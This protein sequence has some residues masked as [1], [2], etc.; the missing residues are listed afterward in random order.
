M[1]CKS[2][3]CHNDAMVARYEYDSFGNCT[4]YDG[5]GTERNDGDFIGNIN[6][7][8]WKSFYYDAE[9]GLYYAN[10]SYYDP[11]TCLYLNALSMDETVNGAYLTRCLDRYGLM[12]DN[13]LNFT[14]KIYSIGDTLNPIN[15]VSAKMLRAL[16][17]LPQWLAVS[18]SALSNTL[19]FS[20]YART[21]LYM[22]R[23]PEIIQLMKFDGVTLLPGKYT[24]FI[25]GAAYGFVA[26]DTVF[27]IY[28]NIQNNKPTGYVIG[29]AVYTAATG[30]GIVWASGKI[31]TVIGT[32]IG[33]P[34]GA[35]AGG[36]I[37]LGAGVLLSWLSNLLKGEIF[38]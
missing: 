12:C 14:N 7:F 2:V 25:N 20:V 21:A 3:S 22:Y 11:K 18:T 4:V 19:S 10:G 15:S 33:G 28:T 35:I 17:S 37:G 8:R 26:L 32:A 31:G 30:A 13:L 6:P 27:D 29:S 1:L 38:K 36:L 16:P 23:Y 9:T 34:V 24:N 5:N